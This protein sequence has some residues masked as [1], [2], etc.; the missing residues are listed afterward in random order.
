MT[1][2]D[3]KESHLFLP[4]AVYGPA[5]GSRPDR[6]PP[7]AHLGNAAL[8]DAVRKAAAAARATGTAA[9]KAE[10]AADRAEQQAAAGTGPHVLAF[11]RHQQD[12]VRRAAAIRKVTEA[13]GPTAEH[14]GILTEADMP[15]REKAALRRRVQEKDNR[16]AKHLR[17]EAVTMRR[18]ARGARYRESGLQEE[19][20]RRTRHDRQVDVEEPSQLSLWSFTP[21]YADRTTMDLSPPRQAPEDAPNVPMPWYGGP[22]VHFGVGSAG[23][24]P[25]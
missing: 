20:E 18:T 2:R 17:T 10:S 7:Y 19:L 3:K 9:E 13:A 8:R 5:P 4:L 12:V 11:E 24:S 14:E 15:E 1:S 16:D 25:F 23:M 22:G 6:G 21:P